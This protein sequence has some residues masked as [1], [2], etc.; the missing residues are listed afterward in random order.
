MVSDRCLDSSTRRYRCQ[1]FRQ[2]RRHFG[3]TLLG[4]GFVS[5]ALTSQRFLRC[6]LTRLM[7][8]VGLDQ[9]LLD[10][11]ISYLI[12]LPRCCCRPGNKRCR[13]TRRNFSRT[14]LC[15]LVVKVCQENK[16]Q[17]LVSSHK[18]GLIFTR[19]LT[20]KGLQ[21]LQMRPGRQV[22]EVHL[23]YFW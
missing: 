15:W 17:E 3:T 16:L 1:H 11:C 2:Y 23:F 14:L 13:S 7:T 18:V 22:S 9:W 20:M 5:T 6:A 4:V 21:G 8:V 12:N 19:A 10:R